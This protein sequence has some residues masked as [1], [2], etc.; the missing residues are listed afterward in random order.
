MGVRAVT[1]KPEASW[2]RSPR[3]G[4]ADAV[5]P[6]GD[7]EVLVDL[8]SAG[9]DLRRTS[10]TRTTRTTGTT[11]LSLVL[12]PVTVR[13]RNHS[14]H[15]H[16]HR[17]HHSSHR[18]RA[19]TT[20]EIP[21][22]LPIHNLIPMV[23]PIYPYGY[24]YPYPF[25]PYPVPPPLAGVYPAHFDQTLFPGQDYNNARIMDFQDVYNYASNGLSILESA[26]M[27]WHEV[28]FFLDL[29]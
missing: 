18:R 17:R 12:S 7:R 27:P 24:P 21:P 10:T 9:T 28:G 13:A 23:P 22:P 26:R 1:K 16:R 19:N 14:H 2:Y 29:I 3:G 6:V 25:P 5:Q 11:V 4:N 20:S 8:L 15:H